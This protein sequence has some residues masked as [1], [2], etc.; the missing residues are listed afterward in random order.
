MMMSELQ[1]LSKALD[2]GE[3]YRLKQEA[4]LKKMIEKEKEIDQLIV[5]AQEK[6]IRLTQL[7]DSCYSPSIV[8]NL[9]FKMQKTH[10]T[11]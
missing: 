10:N 9:N 6:H 4:L 11:K 3:V 8:S 1:Q 2:N 7:L 5:E